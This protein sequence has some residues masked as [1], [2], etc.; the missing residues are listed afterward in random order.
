MQKALLGL[1]LYFTLTENIVLTLY[2][3]DKSENRVYHLQSHQKSLA[4]DSLIKN[5]KNNTFQRLKNVVTS[6]NL[7]FR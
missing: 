4:I 7:K 6:E 1:M 3:H 2:Q 5:T